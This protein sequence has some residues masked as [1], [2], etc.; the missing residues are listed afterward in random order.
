MS[1]YY[2][3]GVFSPH[4]TIM[5]GENRR[6]EKGTV[7]NAVQNFL[8]NLSIKRE[9]NA[10]CYGSLANT[11]FQAL[12]HDESAL[13][14]C[15]LMEVLES[16]Q[17]FVD[18]FTQAKETVKKS[19]PK[20]MNYNLTDDLIELFSISEKEKR[21]HDEN[22]KI[23]KLSAL[24]VKAQ[25]AGNVKRAK[26]LEEEKDKLLLSPS[27]IPLPSRAV[28]ISRPTT[29]KDVFQGTVN[30]AG[31]IFQDKNSRNHSKTSHGLDNIER[32]VIEIK[33][34]KM[35]DRSG[36]DEMLDTFNMKFHGKVYVKLELS[37]DDF[38]KLCYGEYD[39]FS[40]LAKEEC[41][42]VYRFEDFEVCVLH[43][44]KM[45]NIATTTEIVDIQNIVNTV[46]A[47]INLS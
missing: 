1:F 18:L 41:A 45:I 43:D 10:Y 27:A 4:E 38:T 31:T 29:V 16:N 6:F 24:I 25:Q 5:P 15:K 26:R 22:E 11:L 7:D 12:R 33:G 21:L 19:C 3:K 39:V 47:V 42:R 8:D 32:G 20:D 34:T 35:I 40:K 46:C 14:A 17:K 28:T 36:I 13:Q 9:G 30:L 37:F 23:K 2:V 44:I